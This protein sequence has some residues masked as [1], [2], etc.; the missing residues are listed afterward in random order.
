M[1]TGVTYFDKQGCIQPCPTS[2]NTQGEVP[3]GCP[4]I[5]QSQQPDQ[6][7][8]QQ[9]QQP[10]QSIQSS[11]Q[12]QDQSNQQQQPLQQQQQQQ[13]QNKSLTTT[14]NLNTLV[15]LDTDLKNERL[16]LCPRDVTGK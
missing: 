1:S 15:P 6:S 11:V 7:T 12:Q 14:N 13:G 2:S 8:Q 9:Q 10:P 5:P 4:Q 3:I 16:L